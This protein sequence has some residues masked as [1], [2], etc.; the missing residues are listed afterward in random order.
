M[1]WQFRRE[2]LPLAILLTMIV[3]GAIL[4][5]TLP[6]KIPTHFNI[7]GEA[8]HY[9]GR[10]SFMMV[11][12]GLCVALYIVLTFIVCIDP[13]WKKIQHRYDAFMI[14]R[15]LVLLF[16]ALIFFLSIHAARIGR[17]EPRW[18]GIGF[19]L[20]FIAMGNYLPRLPRNFFFGVRSPW[21]L[22]SEEV[23]K[24]THIVSGWLFVAAGLIMIVLAL[25]KVNMMWSM[26]GVLAPLTLF[27]AV[28]YP[29]YLFHKL[30]KQ[31]TDQTDL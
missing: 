30:Q 15:N 20:L 21:T 9:S 24:R 14:L 16:F 17:F 26:L 6:D 18:L 2:A 12:I 23:W 25:C 13:F 28:I 7:Q 10:S 1:N 3:A 22:A 29:Y 31:S 19:G 4:Y 8:D 5:P 11:T 27:C